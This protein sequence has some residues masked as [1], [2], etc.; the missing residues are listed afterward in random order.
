M[1]KVTLHKEIYYSNKGNDFN[2]SENLTF[3][4]KD[5]VKTF[6][7]NLKTMINKGNIFTDIEK[8]LIIVKNPQPEII[9]QCKIT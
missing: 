5:P 6:Q 9:L 8:K 3:I 7:D 1:T 4:P 2:Q